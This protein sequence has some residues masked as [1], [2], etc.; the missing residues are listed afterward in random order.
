MSDDPW[1]LEEWRDLPDHCL[2]AS[3]DSDEIDER[4]PVFLRDGSIHKACPDHWSGIYRVLGA[5]ASWERIDGSRQKA[6]PE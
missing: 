1:R 4:G 6:G 5:Q 2:I 3:C